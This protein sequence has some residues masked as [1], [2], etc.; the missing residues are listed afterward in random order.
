MTDRAESFAPGQHPDLPP[1]S[2]TVGVIGW[3]RGNLISSPFNVALTL[4]AIYL[5][6][7]VV[8]PIIQW[9]FIDADWAGDTRDACSREGAC[10]VFIKVWFKQLMYGRYPVEELWR[11]NTAYVILILAGIP[12][13]I[14]GLKGKQWIGLFLLIGYPLIALYLFSGLSRGNVDAWPYRLMGAS[15]LVL[16]VVAFLPLVGILRER[17]AIVSVVALVLVPIWSLSIPSTWTSGLLRG[18][19]TWAAFA[20]IALSVLPVIAVVA[21]LRIARWR[22]AVAENFWS[23]SLAAA[24]L[25]FIGFVLL[26]L[27]WD[28][29]T[30]PSPPWAIAVALA[31]LTLTVLCPWGYDRLAGGPGR[32]AR[33]LLPVYLV[34]LFL[35][36]TGPPD[37]LNFGSLDWTSNVEPVFAWAETG[38][39]QIETPLWGGMFLTLVIGG[40]GIVGALPIGIVLALGRRSNMPV[41]RSICTAFIELWRGVPLITV[42]FM[43]SVMFPLFLPE[44]MNFDKLIRA[45]LGV[46]L[47]SAAYMAEVVRGG[48]QAIP[49]GQYEAA[50]ALGLSFWKMMGLIVLPQALKLVIPG[51]VNTFI[52]LFKDTTLVLIIGLFDFLGMV[53]L[54]GTNPDWLGFSVEGY[55]FTAFGFWI[56]CFSMSR[57]SQHLEKKLHT[58]H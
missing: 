49:K 51:I 11:I 26:F 44:G 17:S 21:G 10:W 41:V 24:A 36:F 3:V 57:Y 18:A 42:L 30:G 33:L 28:E 7:V 27:T 25:A 29:V 46:M 8:P 48:L 1:P 40:V 31:M 35:A 37:V 5:I 34:A 39:P 52:G 13:F 47:F 32:A 2:S 4:V 22:A 56:F 50:Q 6:Y 23:L 53:Q 9:A 19:P 14:P 55:V 58:G 54:A 20:A 15:A 38:L 45:L 12:L 16:G 43:A